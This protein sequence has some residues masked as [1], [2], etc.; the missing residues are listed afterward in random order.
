MQDVGAR[1]RGI[2]QKKGITQKQAAEDTGITQSFLSAVERGKR[3]VST[4]QIVALIRYYGVS[5]ESVFGSTEQIPLCGAAD[6]P[7][8]FEVDNMLL[9]TLAESSGSPVLET[10]IEGCL[11][12]CIYMLIRTLYKANP[13]NTDKIFKTDYDFAVRRSAE[14]IGSAPSFLQ[15]FL[16]NSRSVNLKCLEIPVE[17]SG[18]LRAFI[19]ECEKMLITD[20]L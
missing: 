17:Y 16:K 14:I 7:P 11:K 4:T 19:E 6:H 5:Y 10:G 20:V 13:R 3:S 12:L 2:R 8:E 18:E 1:L 15:D 9:K